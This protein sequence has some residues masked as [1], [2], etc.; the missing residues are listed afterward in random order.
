[1]FEKK[2]QGI[3]VIS[4][5]NKKR[6]RIFSSVSKYDSKNKQQTK[7]NLINPFRKKKKEIKINFLI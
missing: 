7:V 2:K 6:N 3:K 4:N 1:L 5:K